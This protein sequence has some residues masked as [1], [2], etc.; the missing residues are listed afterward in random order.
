MLEGLGDIAWDQLETSYGSAEEMPHL[1]RA[2][3]YSSKPDWDLAELLWDS[4][5]PNSA[6]N[7]ALPFLID[8]A[9]SVDA[10][11]RTCVLINL[12]RLAR[13]GVDDPDWLRVWERERFRVLA[14]VEDEDPGVRRQAWRT[15]GDGRGSASGVLEAIRRCWSDVPSR[16]DIVV[17]AGKFAA[18][19][20]I[21]AWLRGL[22]TDDPQLRLA[23]A[24]ALELGVEEF[25]PGFSGD[26]EVWRETASFGVVPSAV[27]DKMAEVFADRP[28]EHTALLRELSSVP[29]RVVRNAGTLLS[30]WRSP[31][32]ELL[33][34]VASWLADPNPHVRCEVVYLLGCMRA[35]EHADVI[36]VLLDDESLRYDDR[37]SDVAAWALARCGVRV[38]G[39]VRRLLSFPHST[40]IQRYLMQV[41]SLGE[42]LASMVTEGLPEVAELVTLLDTEHR[43]VAL[44]ALGRIGTPVPELTPADP[45]AAWA[46][47]RCGGDPVEAA[48]V[49]VTDVTEAGVLRRRS[50]HLLAQMGPEAA[51]LVDRLPMGDERVAMR[52][53]TRYAYVRMTGEPGDAVSVCRD[54]LD[55]LGDGRFEPAMIS[56]AWTLVEAGARLDGASAALA[57][58]RRLAR[59]A[60]WRAY[61][62]DGHLREALREL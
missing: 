29:Y 2:R 13:D 7:A 60:G 43:H 3:R 37:I 15:F 53:S 42:T 25:V 39:L 59:F 5:G 35:A 28:A 45:L 33:P 18:D 23:V 32:A 44:Q 6:A 11:W 50:V 20:E 62:D 51:H 52:V 8:L 38:P 4:Y 10:P 54:V 27:I 34:I 56:A 31:A 36:A 12:S 40:P 58:D 47:W 61:D 57:S 9:S 26:L 30:R 19:D 49:I 48:D 21:A 14:L 1:L 24:Y 55:G 41:P 17:A 46:W 16:L 22:P